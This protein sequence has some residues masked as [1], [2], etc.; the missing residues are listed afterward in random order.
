MSTRVIIAG[1]VGGIVL[2]MWG[3]LTHMVIPL[4]ETGFN[5]LSQEQ[6]QK[7]FSATKPTI[8]EPGLYVLPG[9]DQSL[10]GDELTADLE[11][12]SK[13]Y[14]KGPNIF[15]VYH[16]EGTVPMSGKTLGI[17]LLCDMAVALICA[18]FVGLIRQKSFGTKI[19]MVVLLGLLAFLETDAAYANWWR[20]PLDYT[21]AQLL[22][23]LG[24]MLLAGIVL[25]IM[26]K[27]DPSE[28]TP[29]H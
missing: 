9:Y 17:Q 7:V 29:P 26:I 11:R 1:L 10:K 28:E 8:T 6:E 4:G 25:A 2:Y 14:E 13:A 3:F 18:I 21:G 19:G 22:E 20:F 12:W 27:P 15:M 5:Y 24:G 23:K 16:P